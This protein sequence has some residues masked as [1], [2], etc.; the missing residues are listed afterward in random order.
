MS[1]G[2]SWLVAEHYTGGGALHADCEVALL[3]D[4]SRQ[5]DVWG[6]DWYPESHEVRFE[7]LINLR[8]KQGNRS[9]RIADPIL[10]ET[11]AAIVRER[12][13]Q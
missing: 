7:S 4:G 9:M 11:I 2:V 13:G 1:I 3:E 6:A 12:L 10:C 5:G 8:P